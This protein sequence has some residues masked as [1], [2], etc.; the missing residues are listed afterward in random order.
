MQSN[1]RACSR[2]DGGGML[3]PHMLHMVEGHR[4]A[5]DQHRRR[6]A[7]GAR[8]GRG[9]EQHMVSTQAAEHSLRGQ[10]LT[11]RSG[12]WRARGG[13]RAGSSREGQRGCTARGTMTGERESAR[14]RVC[15]WS[16]VKAA[17]ALVKCLPH[18]TLLTLTRLNSVPHAS[19]TD[20][21]SSSVCSLTRQAIT[22][23]IR[24]YTHSRSRNLSRAALLRLHLLLR[25]LACAVAAALK[26]DPQVLV[27][28]LK[29]PVLLHL[30]LSIRHLRTK[31]SEVQLDLE[32]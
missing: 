31:A 26:L 30:L 27:F 9:S 21:A 32:F 14:A 25:R 12:S 3:A 28:L 18:A 4:R 23:Q 13:A 22:T 20:F 29:P 17:V 11:A 16:T 19:S 6:H 5:L 10:S 8:A 2:L 15:E 7:L 24:P 1:G